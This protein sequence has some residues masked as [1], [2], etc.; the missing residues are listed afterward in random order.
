MKLIIDNIDRYQRLKGSGFSSAL[1]IILLVGI[2]LMFAGCGKDDQMN[3]DE[4]YVKY[5]VYSTTIYIGGKLAVDITAEN[6]EIISLTANTRSEWEVVIGP[7]S[8]GFL[9]SLAVSKIGDADSQLR[10]YTQISVSKN[11]SPFA[12]KSIDESDTPRNSAELSYIID[13]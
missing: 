12:L 2:T 3:Q 5:Q 13:Y 4:Y 9:A 6:D 10:L 11:A 1:V 8:R 7:V